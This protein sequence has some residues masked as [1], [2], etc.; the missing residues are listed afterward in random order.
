MTAPR[1]SHPVSA[2]VE[3]Q[4][5]RRHIEK[6]RFDPLHEYLRLTRPRYANDSLL[7]WQVLLQRSWGARSPAYLPFAGALA[8]GAYEGLA[9]TL[10]QP[11]GEEQQVRALKQLVHDPRGVGIEWPGLVT[12]ALKECAEGAPDHRV[13]AEDGYGWGLGCSRTSFGSLS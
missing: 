4:Q 13:C 1:R 8:N 5:C 3:R 12:G 10:I 7:L 6:G 9:Y 2:W 11:G